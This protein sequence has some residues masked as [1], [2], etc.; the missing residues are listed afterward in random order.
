MDKY[1]VEPQL[2]RDVL[3]DQIIAKKFWNLTEAFIDFEVGLAND[4]SKLNNLLANHEPKLL[5]KPT[6][7]EH[8]L[9]ISSEKRP[10]TI[11]VKGFTSCSP[12]IEINNQTS[13]AVGSVF[14]HKLLICGGGL[15]DG[16][17]N[18]V[19]RTCT[20]YSQNNSL[21]TKIDL[22]EKRFQSA[23]VTLGDALWITGGRIKE[24]DSTN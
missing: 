14:D 1:K 21:T 9:V 13:S 10:Q 4:S 2:F 3:M 11:N 5:S 16:Y 18:H 8:V 24:D 19:S 22:V 15:Y 6:Q 17:Q 20:L 12:T 23:A 7:Q